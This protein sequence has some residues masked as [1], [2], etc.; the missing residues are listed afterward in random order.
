QASPGDILWTARYNGPGSYND[1]PAA[2]ASSPDGA[3][4]F[5]TGYSWGS[6]SNYDYATTA[7]SGTSG[8]Q[9][10][11]ARYNGS[12]S[13]NDYANAVAVSPDGARVFVTGRSWDGNDDYFTIAYNA[14]TGSS[15]W[16]ATYYGPSPGDDTATAVAVSPDGA[17]VF[18]TGRSYG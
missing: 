3:R 9:L 8:T 4:V 10:W 17:R 7:Y 2:I 12:P 18:V 15:L 14:F 16:R 11:V 1:S 5:V 6:G 13:N